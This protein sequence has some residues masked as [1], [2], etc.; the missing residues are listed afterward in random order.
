M[1]GCAHEMSCKV[2]AWCWSSPTFAAKDVQ[3]PP[4]QTYLD[5]VGFAALLD[6]D[7]SRGRDPSPDLLL[8]PPS[9]K[10]QHVRTSFPAPPKSQ[11]NP[12]M[13]SNH[14]TPTL[15]LGK[16]EVRGF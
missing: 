4:K 1:Q 5:R 14:K 2:T 6:A 16:Q 13:S 12:E 7:G 11:G 8:I 9:M 10:K 3:P 15:E